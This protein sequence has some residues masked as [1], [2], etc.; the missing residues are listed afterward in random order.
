M[1]H[2][3]AQT[4][5]PRSVKDPIE[6]NLINVNGTLNVLVAARD[7]KSQTRCVCLVLRGSTEKPLSFRFERAPAW[8]RFPRT[9]SPSRWARRMAACF[10]KCTGLSLSRCVTSMCSGRGKIPVLPI[11]ESCRCSARLCSAERSPPCTATELS[12]DFC[13]RGKRLGSEFARRRRKGRARPR[14]QHWH[15]KPLHVES[16]ASA[17]RKNHRPA[18]AREIR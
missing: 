17:A 16:N 1:I 10:K 9:A 12:R 7:A 6:T 14:H 15:G 5:V 18:R 2:L 11:P 8:R 3:A 13:L 4:S